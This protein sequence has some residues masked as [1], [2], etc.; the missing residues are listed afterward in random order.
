MA[1]APAVVTSAL[2]HPACS[3]CHAISE[4][5]FGFLVLHIRIFSSNCLHRQCLGCCPQPTFLT[6]T[7]FYLDPS[8][9]ATSC[10]SKS[11]K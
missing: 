1:G 6:R 8:P 3:D 10:P 7:P 11:N 9:R 4:K 2:F 5:H